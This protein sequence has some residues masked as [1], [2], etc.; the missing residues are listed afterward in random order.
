MRWCRR[1]RPLLCLTLCRGATSSSGTSSSSGIVILVA[2]KTKAFGARLWRGVGGAPRDRPRA[3]G[4]RRSRVWGEGWGGQM[5]GR[6]LTLCV[7][8]PRWATCASV[9]RRS[10]S[11]TPCPNLWRRRASAVGAS[12]LG[13]RR[14]GVWRS[15]IAG[16]W[17]EDAAAARGRT[18]HPRLRRPGR[19]GPARDPR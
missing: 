2:A 13:R 1:G 12:S 3:E 8:S 5:P 19:L 4:L 15:L 7:L 9:D 10:L 14:G 18:M 16:A 11:A 6:L 17:V